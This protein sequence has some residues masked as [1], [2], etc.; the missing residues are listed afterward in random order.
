MFKRNFVYCV[1]NACFATFRNRYFFQ[2]FYS[3][4][5]FKR[6]KKGKGRLFINLT[7]RYCTNFYAKNSIISS[8]NMIH[9][10]EKNNSKINS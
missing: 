4:R 2:Y 10:Q 6:I 3:R 5:R 7:N 8:L 1:R 9:Y